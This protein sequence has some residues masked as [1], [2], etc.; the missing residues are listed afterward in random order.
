MMKNE[1]ARVWVNRV[2]AFLAGGLIVLAIM[3]LAAVNPLKSQKE[4]LAKQLDEVQNGAGRLLAEAKVFVASKSYESALS[5]LKNLYQKHPASAEATEGKAL[6]AGI[7][8]KVQARNERWQAASVAIQAAWEKTT[9]AALR[10]QADLDREQVDKNMTETLKQEWDK[11]KD[12]IKLDWE[13]GE[14]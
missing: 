1:G 12:R 9:A 8:T 11:A 4:A 7:Q 6:D 13:S 5:T 10:A 2:F 14:V 3:S